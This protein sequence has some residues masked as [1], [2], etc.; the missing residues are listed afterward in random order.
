MRSPPGDHDGFVVPGRIEGEPPQ[1]VP[2]CL[3]RPE[4]RVAAE[5]AAKHHGPAVGRQLGRGGLALVRI[6]HGADLPAGPIEPA[7]L[8]HSGAGPVGD[9][10][11]RRLRE[12]HVAKQFGIQRRPAWRPPPARRPAAAR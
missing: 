9:Q 6:A 12:S 5:R 1:D 4:V 11:W 7:E 8:A 10:P 2:A 3:D